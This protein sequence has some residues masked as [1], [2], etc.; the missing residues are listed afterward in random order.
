MTQSNTRRRKQI[1]EAI[2]PVLK[3]YSI[4]T[5][6]H[7]TDGEKELYADL[8]EAIDS[9]G[10]VDKDTL[11]FL[12]FSDPNAEDKV[13]LVEDMINHVNKTLGI[14][15]DYGKRKWAQ[16]IKYLIKVKVEKGWDIQVMWLHL[17]SEELKYKKEIPSIG[18]IMKDPEEV[19]KNWMPIAHATKTDTSPTVYTREK[20]S[21]VPNPNRR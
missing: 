8:V 6:P 9:I 12:G 17:N 21:G 7:C 4:D 16:A 20:K 3:N 13:Q 5:I 10:K 11:G 15:L 18:S 2:E 19:I 1:L 14:Q